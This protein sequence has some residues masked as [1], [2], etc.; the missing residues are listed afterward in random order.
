M[1][2]QTE[3]ADVLV[4]GGGTM[5]QVWPLSD[6]AKAWVEENVQLEGWQWL[7]QSFGVEHR[8]IENLVE[9]MQQA[10]LSVNIS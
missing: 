5:Y 8:Y 7:G 3:Q 6:E 9:G 1:A 4:T 2:Q 10:G